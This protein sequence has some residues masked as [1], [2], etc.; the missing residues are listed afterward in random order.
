[1][2]SN[3]LNSPLQT[4]LYWIALLILPLLTALSCRSY[5][6]Q[7]SA[8]DKVQFY[9]ESLEIMYKRQA[10]N[11]PAD[12]VLFFGDSHIQGLAVT[13]VSP[14]A[15]NF[16]IGH[17]QLQRLSVNINGYHGLVQA[18]KIIIGIG[19]N[20]LLNA[21]EFKPDAAIAQLLNSL[22]CCLTKVVLL[23]ALPVNEIKL[24]KPGLNKIISVFNQQVQE[25]ALTAGFSYIELGPAFVD[26]SGQ[27]APKYDLGDGLHL[28]PAGY[29]LLI[30]QLKNEL[31]QDVTNES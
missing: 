18:E 12:A 29:Q 1:M 19:I 7:Q 27:L 23:S 31:K 17:Q 16:G 13:A 10:Q 11:L 20:D 6:H 5:F 25:T 21:P 30:D 3:H 9:Q 26:H 2:L 15:V 14:K 28:N 4:R 22:Q 24:Q 8:K